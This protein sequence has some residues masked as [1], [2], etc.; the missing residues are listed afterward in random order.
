M[1]V[2]IYC[3]R[4]FF[5]L[6]VLMMI[7]PLAPVMAGGIKLVQVFEGVEFQK[8]LAFIA[9]PGKSNVWYVVEQAGRV[10][11]LQQDNGKLRHSVFIDI[12]IPQ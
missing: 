3:R 5:P 11:R 4:W 6:L 9:A 12:L 10:I 2:L 8:P 7:L 1:R